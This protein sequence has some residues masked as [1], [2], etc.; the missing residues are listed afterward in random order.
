MRHL[1]A[2]FA[3]VLAGC[4]SMDFE[5][6]NPFAGP[7]DQSDRI[8]TPAG[9]TEYRCEGGK[10]FFV[11]FLEN[12]K[13]AWVILP[14]REFRLDQAGDNRYRN[15]SAVLEVGGDSASLNDGPQIAFNGCK[16]GA[17]S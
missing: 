17:A 8:A 3:L 12:R 1:I 5:R 6:F 7:R 14:E 16:S 15:A 11:R 13:S 9:A 2:L 10:R 4:G